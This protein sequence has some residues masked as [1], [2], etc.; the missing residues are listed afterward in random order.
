[1]LNP[2]AAQ[3]ISRTH[4]TSVNW[5]EGSMANDVFHTNTVEVIDRN[6]DGL[7]RG[8]T[9]NP[10]PLATHFFCRQ[11]VFLGGKHVTAMGKGFGTRV[12]LNFVPIANGVKSAP[13]TH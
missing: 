1:M 9:P 4:K 3:W 12:S 7:P 11:H 8:N 10:S 2:A 5:L 6:I 13:N